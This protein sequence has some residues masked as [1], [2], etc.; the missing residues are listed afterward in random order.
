[1]LGCCADDKGSA[2]ASR[3]VAY[4]VIP[5]VHSIWYRAMAVSTHVA[6]LAYSIK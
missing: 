4:E 2:A 5:V 3:N 1:M 6:I